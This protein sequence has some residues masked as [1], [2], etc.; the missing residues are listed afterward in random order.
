MHPYPLHSLW[1]PCRRLDAST[2]T[3]KAPLQNIVASCNSLPLLSS[4]HN[5]PIASTTPPI[6]PGFSFSDPYSTGDMLQ[7]RHGATPPAAAPHCMMRHARSRIA[8]R[9][10]D[11]LSE[12]DRIS[13]SKSPLAVVSFCCARTCSLGR[14]SPVCK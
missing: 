6:L 3:V 9:G 1:E 12:L 5:F 2:L 11:C 7:E 13:I 10:A 14:F 4:A 8:C